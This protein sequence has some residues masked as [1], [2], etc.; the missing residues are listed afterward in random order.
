MEERD[1][2]AKELSKCVQAKQENMDVLKE[3]EEKKEKGN[4][5]TFEEYLRQGEQTSFKDDPEKALK[6][7]KDTS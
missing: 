5:L 6:Q 7:V 2:A 4:V 3:I 1:E